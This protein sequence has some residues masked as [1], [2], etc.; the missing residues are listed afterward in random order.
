VIA[1]AV[2]SPRVARYSRRCGGRGHGGARGPTHES[3]P[4]CDRAHVFRNCRWPRRRRRRRKGGC[5]CGAPPP[6][7]YRTTGASRLIATPG[8][9]ENY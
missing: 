8:D 1:A 3:A 4:M 6:R 5:R 7:A 9:Q 2:V